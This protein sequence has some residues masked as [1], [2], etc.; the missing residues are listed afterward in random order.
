MLMNDVTI[1]SSN[2]FGSIRTGGTSDNPLFCLADVCKALKLS[3]KGVNQRLNKE[4]IS[5]YPFKRQEA[6][7]TLY[8]STR[9][10][11]TM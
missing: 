4:V 9:M 7:N 11:Y 10:V 3:A 8:L 2:A 1:F 6:Y 5:N